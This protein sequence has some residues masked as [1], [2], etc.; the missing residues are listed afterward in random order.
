MI[1]P[2]D[3]IEV[4]IS[5]FGKIVKCRRRVFLIGRSR[6]IKVGHLTRKVGHGQVQK[7]KVYIHESE[8]LK[9]PFDA[10]VA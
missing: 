4:Q 9:L 1:K 3:I 10:E 2:R 7:G 5:C 8:L 6:F